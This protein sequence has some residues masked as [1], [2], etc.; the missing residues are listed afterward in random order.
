M[1]PPFGA[2]D[3]W[4]KTLLHVFPP[5]R[6]ICTF[7]SSVPAHSTPA[8]TGDSAIAV[9]HGHAATPSLRDSTPSVSTALPKISCLL[10]SALVVRSSPSTSQVSPRSVDLNR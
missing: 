1:Y 3:M 9:M 2:P 8:R 10:R 7:P 6:D 4:L 5:S